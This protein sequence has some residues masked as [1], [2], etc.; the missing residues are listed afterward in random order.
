MGW[1]D[2]LILVSYMGLLYGAARAQE[3]LG[4]YYVAIRASAVP[5]I[6]SMA[7]LTATFPHLSALYAQQGSDSLKGAF[8]LSSRYAVLIG[9]PLIVGIATLAY[10]ILL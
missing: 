3:I 8:R 6:F 2:Q 1:D 10:Q 7:I 5:A 9:F 4:V